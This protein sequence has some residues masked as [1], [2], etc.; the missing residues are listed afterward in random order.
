MDCVQRIKKLRS[1]LFHKAVGAYT[2]MGGLPIELDESIGTFDGPYMSAVKG[3][4][5]DRLCTA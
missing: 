1:K 2:M 4:I 5:W 3:M